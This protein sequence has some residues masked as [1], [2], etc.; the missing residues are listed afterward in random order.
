MRPQDMAKIGYLYLNDGMWDGK[1]I[2]SSQWIEASTRK[3]IDATLLPGYGYQWWTVSPGIYTALGHQGQLIIVMPVKNM[4]AVFTSRLS[5]EDFYVPLSLLTSYIIPAAKSPTPLPENFNGEEALKSAITRWQ[6]TSP[7]DR[8]KIIKAEETSQR[9]KL[10][11]YVNNQ[12]GFSAKYDAELLSMDSQLP[13]P[14]VFRRRDLRRIPV[15]AVWVDDIP[16]GMA[17]EDTGDYLMGIYGKRLRANNL[18]IRKQELI[19]LSDGTRA[20]YFEI[21]FS[22]KSAKLL[23]VG[24]FAYKNNKIIG[25]ETVGREKT[26]IE[27]LAGMAK[28]LRFNK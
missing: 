11:E 7:I 12:Y 3:H 23:T 27:Y 15:F 14:L 22:Y 8:K 20:N 16:Q 5:K 2:I 26:P 6:T 10:E 19:L 28:S 4:V 18:E 25:V 17:L 9:L 13:S 1:Q 21:N 24:V